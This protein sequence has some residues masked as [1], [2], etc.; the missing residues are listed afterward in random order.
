[1]Y[2]EI[3]LLINKSTKK[4]I[5]LEELTDELNSL[6]DLT[7]NYIEDDGVAPSRACGT[8]WIGSLVKALQSAINKFGIYLTDLENFGKNKRSENKGIIF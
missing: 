3:I 5:S 6:E 1:M 2:N 8:M 7:D 4:L